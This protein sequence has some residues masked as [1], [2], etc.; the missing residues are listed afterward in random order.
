MEAILI[1][2]D[3]VRSATLRHEVPL[4]IIDPFTYL[5]FDGRRVVVISVLEADRIDDVAPD[6]EIID[7]YALG[8]DAMIARGMRWDE[9]EVELALKVCHKFG[10]SKVVVP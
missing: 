7:P 5:E 9:S 2:A 6:I 3:T 1:H 8:M 10:V 4:A